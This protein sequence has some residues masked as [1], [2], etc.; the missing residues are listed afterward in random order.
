MKKIDILD[1]KILFELDQDSRQSASKIGK[2]L[3]TNK[4]VINFRINKLVEEG[5]IRQFVTMISPS[6]LGLKPYKFYLQLQNL[7][8][9]KER[10]IE[11]IGQKLPVYWMA[12]VS[13]KWDLIIGVLAKSQKD[14]NKIK[15]ELL[16]ILN[17][18][19]VNK[20]FSMVTEAP[21]YYRNYLIETKE[22]SKVKYWIGD[23]NTKIIDKKDYEIIKIMAENSR[24]QIIELAKK[25][26]LNVKTVIKRT[27][28]LEKEG[29]IY[30][31]R[32]SLNLNKM[33]Y[34]YYKCF[35]TLKNS[36][37]KR[38]KEFLEY[39]QS[40]KNIIHLIECVGDWD[41]EP[42][43]EAE[44]DE[45]FYEIINEIREKF[46]DIFREI[47]TINIIKEYNYVCLP[48]AIIQ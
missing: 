20:T 36:D 3:K 26:K 48:C 14:L 9:D 40:N 47:E 39:C 17:D 2:K 30:D 1:R 18:N 25:V 46:K 10:T 23:S 5:V 19:I 16:K 41:Y 31:Y 4:N 33:G 45:K 22:I 24:I 8:K 44:S 7:T 27:K 32:I 6:N 37:N 13:G 28:K 42:E 29:V 43:I 21:Q 34:K 12:R 15:Q 38:L 35:L 11:E